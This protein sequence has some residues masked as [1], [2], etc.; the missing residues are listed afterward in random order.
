MTPKGYRW[1]LE[2]PPFR[3][4]RATAGPA[5]DRYAIPKD[6]KRMKADNLTIFK[7]KT[8]AGR[9]GYFEGQGSGRPSHAV[10]T[11]LDKDKYTLARLQTV[12][13]CHPRGG[14][15][16]TEADLEQSHIRLAF[17]EKVPG[18]PLHPTYAGIAFVYIDERGSSVFDEDQH[19]DDCSCVKKQGPQPPIWGKEEKDVFQTIFLYQG[20][21]DQKTCFKPHTINDFRE[22]TVPTQGGSRGGGEAGT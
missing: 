7:P 16:S 18:W 13:L 8:I 10:E 6:P 5:N 19:E 4:F 9:T 22:F 20:H 1:R 2:S 12:N 17:M 21:G 14:E 11:P 3:Q 15:N